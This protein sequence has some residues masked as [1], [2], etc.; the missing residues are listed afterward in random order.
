MFIADIGLS[1]RFHN[2]NRIPETYKLRL[3][4]FLG[5]RYFT[6]EGSRWAKK[7]KCY[8]ATEVYW[9]IV[10]RWLWYK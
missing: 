4:T 10:D 2:I 7:T 5:F 3:K 6:F 1:Q 8:K 9:F